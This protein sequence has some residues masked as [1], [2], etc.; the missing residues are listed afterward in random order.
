[1]VEVIRAERKSSVL[2]M[3]GLPCLSRIP[4][5]NLTSGCA[6]EC[7]YCYTRGYTNYPGEGRVVFYTN[8]LEKL[9]A[10]LPRKRERPDVVYF[11]PSSDLYQPIPEVLE[12]SYEIMEYLFAQNVAVAFLTKGQIPERHMRLLAANARRVRAAI[13]LISLDNR[14][15]R[16]FEANAVS[17]EIR[18]AQLKEIA[19]AGIVSQVR[20]DPV[21][22]GLT[23]DPETIEA[24]CDAVSKIGVKRMAVSVLFLRPAVA[25]S[26]RRHLVDKAMREALFGRFDAPERLGIREGKSSVMA[27]PAPERQ[28][29]HDRVREIAGR[30]AI[31]IRTCSCKNPDITSECCSI[32]GTSPGFKGAH[33]QLDLLGEEERSNS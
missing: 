13:G 8:T 25:E 20:L 19:A 16:T 15:Q 21:L 22:P 6:H 30:H 29:I 28:R 33:E 12:L 4:A 1:M 9:R 7:L 27:L 17:P 14:I 26:L 24:I 3:P 2:S 11:S 23:D 10:E 32:A 18:L 31:A 5:I